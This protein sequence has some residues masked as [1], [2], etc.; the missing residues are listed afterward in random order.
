MPNRGLLG[1]GLLGTARSPRVGNPNAHTQNARS[2]NAGETP[3]LHANA[4]SFARRADY[5]NSMAAQEMFLAMILTNAKREEAQTVELRVDATEARIELIQSGGS[6]RALVA[7]P[8]EI[9]MG[10]IER[11]EQGQREFASSVF[12]ATVDSVQITRTPHCTQA[13]VSSWTITQK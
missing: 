6:R 2:Q 3:A 5:K 4:L 13:A 10:L 7:P 8:G 11:L 12:I 1:C 9:L